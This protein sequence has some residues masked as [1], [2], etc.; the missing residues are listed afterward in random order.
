VAESA[1]FALTGTV[2]VKNFRGF[3]VQL[4]HH[5]FAPHTMALGVPEAS[6]AD[7]ERQVVRLAP[8]FVRIFYNDK[9]AGVPF[10][11]QLRP[12]PENRRQNKGQ[13]RRWDSFVRVCKL[14]Q[15]T[16]ATINIT[17]QGG[18]LAT[19]EQRKTS[20]TRFANVLEILRK[21]ERISNLRWVTIANEPN[22]PPRRR[23]RKPGETV[24]PERPKPTVTPDRLADMYR[25]LDNQLTDK[26]LRQQIRFMGGD[27]IDPVKDPTSPYHEKRW[28]EHMST[29]L[30]DILNAYSIHIYWNYWDVGKFKK[31]LDA[32]RTIVSNLKHPMPV[33][34]TEFGTRGRERRPNTVNDPGNFHEGSIKIPLARSKVAAFQHA[35][36]QILALQHGCVGMAKWDCHFG[37]YD[38]KK[39]NRQAYYAIGPPG[40]P[41]Q[42][43]QWQPYPMYFL[44][45]L[46]T[47]TSAPG[48]KVLRVKRN[49]TASA[50][51]HLVALTG[52]GQ[53]LTILGLDESGATRER[54][55]KVKVPY[56]IG[57]LP[58]L[59]PFKLLLWNRAGGGKLVLDRTVSANA[60]GTA[61][62]N[63]PLHSVFALTTKPLP[64]L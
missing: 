62:I 9:H 14:A 45:R 58:P 10:D 44:L 39:E 48:W 38:L 50:T 33:Y 11:E 13:E 63:V 43:R 29:N 36:F 54:S 47:I 35:L 30:H 21:Q 7:L 1:E 4:N 8:Q 16:G 53:G 2:L 55:S 12:S 56:T 6:F 28:F 19:P 52:D 34:I 15:K 22:T 51:K 31:R 57:G 60:A 17:W 61:K 5:V 59:T 64:P 25:R 3:G 24:P 49:P 27:L 18:P 40:P 37:K 20:V 32:V 42:P 41:Q 26:R 23:K 46:M